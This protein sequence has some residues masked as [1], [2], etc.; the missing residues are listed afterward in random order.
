[1]TPPPNPHAAYR[2]AEELQ[3]QHVQFRA[4]LERCW[5]RW[6]DMR[7]Y[8]NTARLDPHVRL[9]TGKVYQFVTV[10]VY[11][12]AAGPRTERADAAESRM[13]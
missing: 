13:R 4:D 2:D 8:A 9:E 5:Q 10:T 7:R 1:M 6:P 11:D 3:A 12:A